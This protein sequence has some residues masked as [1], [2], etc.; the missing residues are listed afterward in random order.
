MIPE[1]APDLRS[2]GDLCHQAVGRAAIYA[3]RW[4]P[5]WVGEALNALGVEVNQVGGLFEGRRLHPRTP[6]SQRAKRAPMCPSMLI[7][8]PIVRRGREGRVR[9]GLSEELRSASGPP[10]PSSH[11]GGRDD[12]IRGHVGVAAGDDVDPWSL[13]RRRVGDRFRSVRSPRDVARRARQERRQLAQA[14][15]GIP[16]PRRQRLE[17]RGPAGRRSSLSITCLQAENSKRDRA[18]TE[19]VSRL[20]ASSGCLCRRPNNTR[21]GSGQRSPSSPNGCLRGRK[22]SPFRR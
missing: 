20:L 11:D 1:T 10:A 12:G 6:G 14:R 15:G 22:S 8:G 18:G 17:R 7:H 2:W 5:A 9:L 21:R 3:N 13:H 16:Q 4:Q 19:S